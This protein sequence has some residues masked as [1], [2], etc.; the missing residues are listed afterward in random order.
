VFVVGVSR[1]VESIPVQSD[2]E[3]CTYL[4]S[5]IFVDSGKKTRKTAERPLFAISLGFNGEAF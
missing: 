5:I 3:T 2:P 4:P 1:Q